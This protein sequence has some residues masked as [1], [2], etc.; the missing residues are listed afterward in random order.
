MELGAFK[1]LVTSLVMPLSSLLLFVVAG[2]VLAYKSK[3]TGLLLSFTATA[4]LW[5]LSCQAVAV[6]LAVN[7]L[8]Q[9]PAISPAQIKANQVQVIVVLSGGILPEAP[10]YGQAQPG[11][12]TA[13]RLRYGVWLAKETSLPVAF[14]G[15][16]GWAASS[17]QTNSEAEVA[18]RVAAQDYGV[19]LRWVE[20]QS[21][22]TAENASLLAPML[23]RDGIT[24]IALV[25]DALHMPRSVH[26]F[27]RYELSITPAPTGFVQ[28]TQLGVLMWLPSTEGL[29]TTTRVLHEVLG[30]TVARLR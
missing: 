3:R 8:S 7:V 29:S 30:L 22:D 26:E 1:P 9:H 15:G 10:E 11:P 2:L 28:L 23:K 16:S 6:W 27:G 25:T 14:T 20:T 24:R 18:S 13:A 5:L 19:A 21:R 12:A 17:K 4:C